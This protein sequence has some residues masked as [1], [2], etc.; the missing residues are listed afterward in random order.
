MTKIYKGKQTNKYSKKYIKGMSAPSQ[1]ILVYIQR[2]LK[3]NW[4]LYIKYVPPPNTSMN[5]W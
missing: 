4:N 1:H 3:L 5:I 2:K